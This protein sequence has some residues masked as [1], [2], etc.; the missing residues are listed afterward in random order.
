MDYNSRV[1]PAKPVY[2]VAVF[3]GRFQPFHNGHKAVIEKALEIARNVIVLIGSSDSPRSYYNPF[4]F[5]E[6]ADMIRDSFDRSL[7]HLHIRGISDFTY[8]EDAWI[9]GV[10]RRVGAVCSLIAPN[11]KKICLIGHSKDSTSYYLKMFPQ[12]EAVSVENFGGLSST[13]MRKMY[14]SEISDIKRNDWIQTACT[15]RTPIIPFEVGKFLSIF[16]RTENFKELQKEFKFIE[17]YAPKWG[18]GPFVTTD[19]VVVQGGH[20]LMIRRGGRPGIGQLALPGGFL[21]RDEFLRDGCIRELQEETKIDVPPE[22]LFNSIKAV[23]AFDSPRRD[24]RARII[25]HAFLISLKKAAK[26]PSVK[27]S[28]DAMEALWVPIADLKPS[29]CFGDHWHIVQRMRGYL[30]QQPR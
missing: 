20:V 24:P 14:F 15:S 18:K 6:R 26:L 2:D 28:D 13:P 10:Q 19:A 23:E 22:I 5:E 16:S 30:P 29:E 7:F 25:T 8:N 27:G 21:N 11:P 3:I 17:E 1:V 4:T 9:S 12:W